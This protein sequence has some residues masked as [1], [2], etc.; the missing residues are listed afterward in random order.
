MCFN[1]VAVLFLLECDNIT[2]DAALNERLR[3]RVETEGLVELSD[4]Q[5]DTLART[6]PIHIVLIM[7]EVL[8]AVA[9]GGVTGEFKA[10]TIFGTYLAFLLAGAAEAFGE[11]R[12]GVEV[13]KEIGKTA[14]AAGLGLVGFGA[15]VAMSIFNTLTH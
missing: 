8:G 10:A 11:W 15:L 1:T 3:S 12:S 2:F 9:T 13:C 5:A 7:A 6:K 14:G 4:K